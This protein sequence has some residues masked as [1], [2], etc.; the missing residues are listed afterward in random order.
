[1]KIDLCFFLRLSLQRIEED[2]SEWDLLFPSWTNSHLTNQNHKGSL[3]F[4]VLHPSSIGL[5]DSSI[6]DLS[7]IPRKDLLLG[8]SLP[9]SLYTGKSSALISSD[10]RWLSYL[11]WLLCLVVKEHR[12]HLCGDPICGYYKSFVFLFTSPHLRSLVLYLYGHTTTTTIHE[13]ANPWEKAAR[14]NTDTTRRASGRSR[15]ATRSSVHARLVRPWTLS[16]YSVCG[17][18]VRFLFFSVACGWWNWA[19]HPLSVVSSIDIDQQL[20][21]WR[22][23]YYW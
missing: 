2:H 7:F 16:K 23:K 5:Q 6:K 10:T 9:A 8:P 4:V 17:C 21:D 12:T 15:S 13:P 1:M 20:V 14:A 22:L 11:L 19:I 3:F 18:C